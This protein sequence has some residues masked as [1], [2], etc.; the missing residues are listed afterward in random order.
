MKPLMLFQFL[1]LV[2]CV[3]CFVNTPEENQK[4]KIFPVPPS[5]GVAAD[6]LRDNLASLTPNISPH[7]KRSAHNSSG[8]SKNVSL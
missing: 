7:D 5:G 1:I 6:T 2:E 3:F 8:N 4:H